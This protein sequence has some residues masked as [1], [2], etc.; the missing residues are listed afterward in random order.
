[1]SSIWIKNPLAVYTPDSVDAGGG[2]VV[3]EQ[4]IIELIPKGSKPTA[5]VDT[6]FDAGCHVVLPGLVNT[7]HHFYQTLTRAVPE[8]CGKELFDWLK[9]LYNIWAKLSPAHIESSSRLALAE[10]LLSGCTTA[11]DHHYVFPAGL[12]HAID[13][14]IGEA[15]KLGIRVA[16]TRGSMSLSVEEGGLP[17][18][19]VVQS[20]EVILADSERPLASNHPT[21]PGPPVQILLAPCSPFSVSET[22]LA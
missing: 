14:Q 16:L 13:L 18:K 15:E 17:P 6:I 9:V 11:S 21:A 4:Q 19:S 10:L 20:E 8:A 3:K 5:Q 12:E 22:L 1:M 2:L 7:H